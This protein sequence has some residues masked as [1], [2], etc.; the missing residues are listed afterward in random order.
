MRWKKQYRS[1]EL[2]HSKAKQL[3]DGNKLIWNNNA[4][5]S[6]ICA[7]LLMY[8]HFNYEIYTEYIEFHCFA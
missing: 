8:K 3:A 5:S 7:N 1:C 4:K 2:Y 6:D